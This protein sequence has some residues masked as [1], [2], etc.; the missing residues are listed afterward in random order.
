MRTGHINRSVRETGHARRSCRARSHASRSRRCESARATQSGGGCV[1]VEVHLGVI[2]DEASDRFGC[3]CAH[4]AG[5]HDG[6]LHG[7][8]RTAGEILGGRGIGT[9][10]R[11]AKAGIVHDGSRARQERSWG[12]SSPCATR[13]GDVGFG[14]DGGDGVCVRD[15]GGGRAARRTHVRVLRG[16]GWCFRGHRR[17]PSPLRR[18][19]AGGQGDVDARLRR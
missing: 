1:V 10:N 11:G 18:H 19:G 14:R 17:G 13:H 6:A 3:G 2:G 12:W 15:G 7:R 5:T 9:R 8:R 16:H 4:S